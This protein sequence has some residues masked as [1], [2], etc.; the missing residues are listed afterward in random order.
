MAAKIVVLQ[1]TQGVRV[2]V[3]Q[4]ALCV[5]Y[6]IMMLPIMIAAQVVEVPGRSVYL[7]PVGNGKQTEY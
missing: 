1:V 6:P 4:S 7:L 3:I 2:C 5:F